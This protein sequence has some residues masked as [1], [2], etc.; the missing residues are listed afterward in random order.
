MTYLR[1]LPD[2]DSRFGRTDI[3]EVSDDNGIVKK[4]IRMVI[5]CGYRETD[6]EECILCRGF[7]DIFLEMTIDTFIIFK[8][9]RSIKLKDML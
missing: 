6:V 2:C 1:E 3:D 5:C 7:V 8:K 9:G 4:T